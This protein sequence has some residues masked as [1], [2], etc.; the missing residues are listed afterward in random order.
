M[1][2]PLNQGQFG[3]LEALASNRI[4]S[5]NLPLNDKSPLG[6]LFAGAM[7]GYNQGVQNDLQRSQANVAQQN[8][9][10]S[11]GRLAL[12]QQLEP[13]KVA[14]QRQQ[15]AIE[16]QRN[17]V[18]KYRIDMEAAKNLS[19]KQLDQISGL[20]GGYTALYD[21]AKTPQDKE[22][23][24]NKTIALGVKLGVLNESQA[25]FF[26][27]MDADTFYQT[28]NYYQSVANGGKQ[29]KEQGIQSGLN[30]TMDP[31]TGNPTSLSITPSK[32]TET[33]LQ[34][35]TISAEKVKDAILN[36]RTAATKQYLGNEATW[37]YKVL[38]AAASTQ[39]P[40]AHQILQG[41][42]NLI[43]NPTE[44][45]TFL[46]NKA[47]FDSDAERAV[48]LMVQSATNGQRLPAEERARL[49]KLFL[50][51]NLS[52]AAF[53]GQLDSFYKGTTQQQD[54]VAKTLVN[55]VD[56]NNKV[57]VDALNTGKI[58]L[59]GQP[60]TKAQI[61]ATIEAVVAKYQTTTAVATG[62][63]SRNLTKGN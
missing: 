10:I 32:E 18:E 55:G 28:A 58:L 3:G 53:A 22:A 46:K 19:T 5:L 59:N 39:M 16:A 63:V 26:N 24:K 44:Q 47:A 2:I 41:A 11:K 35:E 56:L 50:D 61:D 13:Q 6:S 12:D 54:T 23:A 57:D 7:Q 40:V 8:V 4:G 20:G 42:A 9:D 29:L 17:A 48:Q 52:D 51:P 33:K 25:E 21:K 45:E 31:T 43:S 14:I 15:A 34:Q 30:I 36:L 27:T 49:K 37:K 38:N 62:I 1:A 60:V